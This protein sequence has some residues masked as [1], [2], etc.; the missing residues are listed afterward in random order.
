MKALIEERDRLRAEWFV[1]RFTPSV[2]EDR[3]NV[4]ST[5]KKSKTHRV[6]ASM[7]WVESNRIWLTACGV[8]VQK[9]NGYVITEEQVSCRKCL[10]RLGVKV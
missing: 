7:L 4:V 6:F 2:F 3:P 10:K 8:W 1:H 5:R 9:K